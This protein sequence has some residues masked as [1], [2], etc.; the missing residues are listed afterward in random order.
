MSQTYHIHTDELRAMQPK[1][2]AGD[3]VILS[4]TIYTARDAAHKRM[5]GLLDE[6]KELPF[7]L[8]DAIIYYAGPTPAQQGMAVGAC[9][10]TTAS[11]MNAFAPRLLDLGLGA[12]IAKG[13]M[14]D[15]VEAAMQRNGCCFFAAVG[16]AGALIARCIQIADV[17]AFDDLGCESIKRITIQELP[18][19]VAI[20]CHGGN[21]YK[22]GRAQYEQII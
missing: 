16:G 5:F 6:G 22:T 12:I 9:G 4:G 7:P 19:T 15:E 17:I 20:D 3:R 13:Q 14:S 1:L 21:L 2:N 18:L 8:Q 11:R 10:P